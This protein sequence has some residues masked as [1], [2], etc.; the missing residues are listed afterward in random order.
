MRIAVIGEAADSLLM[1]QAFNAAFRSM[2]LDAEAISLDCERDEFMDCVPHLHA[3]GFKGISVGNPH[4]PVAAKL[5]F[6]FYVVKY[7]LGV[8][9][10][11][12]LGDNVFAQNTEVPAFC[13]LIAEIPPGTA[14]VM[15]SGRAARS[16]VM[17]LFESGW[18]VKLWNR[19]LMRSKPLV[20]LFTRYGKVDTIPQADPSGCS[21][22][23]NATTLGKRA[24]E[25]PPLLWK[26]ARPHTTLV[27]YVYRGVATEFL[28]SGLRHG[29]KTIDGRELL[30]E[31]AAFA[32]EW[33]IQKAAPRDPMLYAVGF[34]KPTFTAL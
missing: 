29:F 3:A 15:G 13:R 5:A 2:E 23:V 17:G 32:I 22:V 21:L 28:R 30:V 9:N 31:Q 14:L 34:K 27:D 10:A 11:L 20:S 4:K 18:Q 16:A 8:A 26:H 25:Q 24:G 19:N 6:Q 12:A 33:W 1:T 7:A